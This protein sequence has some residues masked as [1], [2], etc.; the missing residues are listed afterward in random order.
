MIDR[1]TLFALLVLIVS[2]APRIDFG[3]LENDSE[4]DA[5]RCTELP[6]TTYD[7]GIAMTGALYLELVEL[8]DAEQIAASD[9][10]PDADDLVV[11]L[12]DGAA[13]S[14]DDIRPA[15]PPGDGSRALTI[16]LP[17]DMDGPGD[18]A[19]DESHGDTTPMT[20]Y[21]GPGAGGGPGG[22]TY[23]GSLPGT[24]T[25]AAISEDG[26]VG[27]ACFEDVEPYLL[28]LGFEL[29]VPFDVERCP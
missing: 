1:C 25:L 7:D 22:G 16:A 5:P 27:A 26:V 19:L 29:S 21:N 13:V 2:C 20:A 14:C 28:S 8:H 11:I 12:V 24:L 9:Q 15:L 10:L 23:G 18:Y 3:G 17:A 6:A 4:T